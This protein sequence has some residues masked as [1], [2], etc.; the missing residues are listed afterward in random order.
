MR[1]IA[2]IANAV[3][4]ARASA[5]SVSGWVRG[6]RKPTSTPPRRRRPISSSEGGATMTTTSAAH[7]SPIVAP[8]SLYSASGISARSPAP[9]ST[10]TSTPLD[11]RR[12]TTSGTSATRRSPGAVS[13]GTPTFMRGAKLSDPVRRGR[14][15]RPDRQRPAR[16]GGERLAGDPD[17]RLRA[18]ARVSDGP[19]RGHQ[20]AQVP[21]RR[22]RSAPVHAAGIAARGEQRLDRPRGRLGVGPAAG[23][24]REAAVGVLVGDDEARRSRH[25][26]P[27]A[28]AGGGE[29]LHD[30]GGVV[31]PAGRAAPGEVEAAVVVGLAPEP[32]RGARDAAAAGVCG[33]QGEDAERRA[34]DQ[35]LP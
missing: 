28:V 12:L 13:F 16:Q 17:R 35:A 20:R 25:R 3:T 6:A 27:A 8:A 9:D 24:Q 33:A 10:T 11:F 26:A 22:A 29:R 5:L 31:D 23:L 15:P 18:R 1:G 19:V 14:L 21:Q 30:G 2:S 34:V 7:G 4:P 32:A